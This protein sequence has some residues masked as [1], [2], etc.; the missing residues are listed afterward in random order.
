MVALIGLVA[1]APFL[2]VRVL[3]RSTPRVVRSMLRN[4]EPGSTAMTTSPTQ[5]AA[6]T[7]IKTPRSSTVTRRHVPRVRLVARPSCDKRNE[8]CS[9]GPSLTHR[10]RTMEEYS[11]AFD[12]TG[13]LAAVLVGAADGFGGGFVHEEH[14]AQVGHRA[15]RGQARDTQA[16]R[17]LTAQEINLG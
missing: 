16:C 11:G 12:R 8:G 13:Q 15:G 7:A 2:V 4:A 6:Q 3:Q 14:A 1:L 9:D 5:A 10:G 17:G